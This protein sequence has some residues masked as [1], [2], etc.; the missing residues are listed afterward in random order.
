MKQAIIDDVMA[1]LEKFMTQNIITK[2]DLHSFLG[3]LS[4]ISGLLIVMR[5]FLIPIWAAWGGP[6]PQ[7]RPGCIWSSQ[8]ITETEWLKAFFTGKGATVERFFTV[9]AYNRAGTVVEIGTD[10]SPWGLGGWL[11]ING[12]I[13]QYFTSPLS[14]A[15]IAKYGY[16]IGDAAGQQLWEALA[17]LV[18]VDIWA[19]Y[20]CQQRVILKVRGDNVAALVLLIKLSLIHI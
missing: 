7:D 6:S 19:S 15:D 16:A 10:A 20:W 17:I 8:I 5:P 3:K 1:D 4:H 2:K 9:D 12:D 11:A 18:A 13:K 14:D